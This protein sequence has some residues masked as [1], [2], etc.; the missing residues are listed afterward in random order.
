MSLPQLPYVLGNL[1][2]LRIL[3]LGA[4]L[5]LITSATWIRPFAEAKKH[6]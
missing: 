2:A 5:P 4:R 6:F 1:G 3:T